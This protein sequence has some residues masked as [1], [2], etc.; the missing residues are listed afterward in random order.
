MEENYLI[1][2]TEGV[3][4]EHGLSSNN[5][6]P[7]QL[8]ELV[9]LNLSKL[10]LKEVTLL[11]YCTALKICNLANN[12]ITDINP[13]RRCAQLV[14]LDLHGNQLQNLPGQ[15]FW[16]GMKELKLLY[17]HNNRIRSLSNV[18]SLSACPALVGITLYDTPLS[19]QKNYRHILVNSIWTLKALDNFVISDEEIIEDWNLQGRFKALSPELQLTLLSASRKDISVQNETKDTSEIITKINCVLAAC[20]PVLIVQKWIRGYLVRRSSGLISQPQT[21]RTKLHC[22]RRRSQEEERKSP[23]VKSILRDNFPA[24][25]ASSS[26]PPVIKQPVRRVNTPDSAPVKHITVDLWKIQQDVLQVLPETESARIHRI[27]NQQHPS[28]QTTDPV[29]KEDKT[30]YKLKRHKGQDSLQSEQTDESEFNLLGKKAT[31][32]ESDSSKDLQ[33]YNERS[34]KDIRAS[35]Q[36]IH[37]TMETKQKPGYRI[38]RATSKRHSAQDNNV[39]NLLPLYAIDKAYE[40]REKSNKL[41]QKRN[42]VVNVQSDKRQA[43]YHIEEFLEGRKKQAIVQSQKDG[44][45]LQQQVEHNLLNKLSFI[46]SVRYRHKCF[47]QNKEAKKLDYALAK[48]FNTQHTSVTKTLMRHDRLIRSQNDMQGKVKT[49]QSLKE[50]REKQKKFIKCLQEHRQ[51]VLQIENSSEKVALDSLVLQKAS[52]RLQEARDHVTVKKGQHVMAEPMDKIPVMQ[53]ASKET[54]IQQ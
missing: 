54:S 40:N 29:L 7:T 21:R 17:L 9:V 36:Q 41:I 6:Q 11:Q 28:L 47:L 22:H 20:S 23:L 2:A 25:P 34:A 30:D 18:E 10:F 5:C 49:V 52:E 53:P 12:F 32:H 50:D 3:L 48:E 19:L 45:S 51:L 39:I 13:L 1:S 38:E 37:S 43:R 14:K 15:D 35:I 27:Q 44:D 16:R 4:L 26:K 46:D 42:L 33:R 31:V 24:L 8:E